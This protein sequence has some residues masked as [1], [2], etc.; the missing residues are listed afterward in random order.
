MYWYNNIW[1]DWYPRQLLNTGGPSQFCTSCF[2]RNGFGSALSNLNQF[3]YRRYVND[4]FVLLKSA[5][6]LTRFH[7][8]LNICHSV[9][10]NFDSF[11]ENT[12]QICMIYT[13]AH[14]CFRIYSDWHEKFNYLKQVFLKKL[15]LLIGNCFETFVNKLS[16]NCPQITALRNR[17]WFWIFT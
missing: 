13:L 12:I 1:L 2:S 3:F 16:M 17:P 5:N 9:Y 11:F 8:Y 10:N 4:I 15:L 7:A 6:H 14:R